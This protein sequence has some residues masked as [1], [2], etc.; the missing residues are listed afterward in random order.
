MR[1]AAT[2]ILLF[3]LL[4]SGAE[5]PQCRFA[6][7]VNGTNPATNIRLTALRAI[8]TGAMRKWPDKQK[9]IP[10]IRNEGSRPFDFLISRVLDL[11]P[12]EYHRLLSNVEFS[13]ADPVPLKV[14]N[15]DSGACKFVLNVPLAVAVIE[16]A[17]TTA[18]ECAGVKVLRVDGALPGERG[19]KLQ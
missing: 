2:A 6:V 5:T 10:V 14:L 19:Y 9:L 18:P 3:S 11:N 16:A 15:N 7:V 8:Y 17:S 13:G 12:V 4:A 1:L